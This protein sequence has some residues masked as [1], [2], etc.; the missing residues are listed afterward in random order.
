MVTLLHAAQRTLDS[1]GQVVASIRPGCEKAR[2]ISLRELA[3]T[4]VRQGKSSHVRKWVGRGRS[5]FSA[6][7]RLNEHHVIDNVMPVS[8]YSG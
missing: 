1:S 3:T 8:H 5:A 6:A 2:R 7:M 4:L